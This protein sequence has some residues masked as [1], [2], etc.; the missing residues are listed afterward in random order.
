MRG[1]NP[2]P[3]VSSL[4]PLPHRAFPT[5]SAIMA[6]SAMSIEDTGAGAHNPSRSEH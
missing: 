5:V 1:R 6:R 2:F 3:N 4:L